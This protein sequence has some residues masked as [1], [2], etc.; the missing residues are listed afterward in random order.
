MKAAP[1]LKDITQDIETIKK[2]HNKDSI[3][4]GKY[5]ALESELRF[6]GGISMVKSLKKKQKE[7]QLACL[8]EPPLIRS[9]SQDDHKHI[10]P[11]PFLSIPS[12]LMLMPPPGGFV[13]GKPIVAEQK[14]EHVKIKII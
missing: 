4:L 10:S 7:D 12:R 1:L 3:L 5:T 11:P 2:S 6:N 13:P 9:L 14:G 8:A